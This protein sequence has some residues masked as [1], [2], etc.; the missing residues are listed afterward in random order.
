VPDRDVV[1]VCALCLAGAAV[2]D[3]TEADRALAATAL[4]RDLADTHGCHAAAVLDTASGEAEAYLDASELRPDQFAAALERLTRIRGRADT[5]LLD[6]GA[7]AARLP[8]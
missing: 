7:S 1:E 5:I 3:G 8:L 2:Y 6:F 4:A